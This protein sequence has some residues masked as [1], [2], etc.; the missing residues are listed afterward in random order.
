MSKYGYD[1]SKLKGKMREKGETYLTLGSKV[2]IS[3]STMSQKLNNHSQ[4]TQ[5]E[6][7]SILAAL[8]IPLGDIDEYFFA[9]RV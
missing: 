7:T 1:Y 2:G 5:E 3:E 9:L 6:M 4:F 8:D